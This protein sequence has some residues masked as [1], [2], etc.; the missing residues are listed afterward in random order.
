MVDL[1]YYSSWYIDAPYLHK[2]FGIVI[3]LLTI[4]RFLWKILTPSPQANTN[5]SIHIQRLSSIAHNMMYLCLGI[6]FVSGYLIST[7][8]GRAIQVFNLISI[9]ALP[10]SIANQ[11]ELA[12]VIHEYA[13]DLLMLIVILHVVAALKHHFIDKDN[14]LTRILK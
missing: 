1:D 7:A 11:T 12:G 13:T 6:I 5:H 14:T 10:T 8:D 3:A 9:P 4:V 2:S